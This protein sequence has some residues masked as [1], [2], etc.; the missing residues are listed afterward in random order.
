MRIF[1]INSKNPLKRIVFNRK[2][3]DI[4]LFAGN[5]VMIIVQLFD[6]TELTEHRMT[7]LNTVYLANPAHPS[8]PCRKINALG[9]AAHLS[10][11]KLNT[12]RYIYKFMYLYYFFENKQKLLHS[13][14]D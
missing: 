14:S 7:L 6:L 10:L 9:G 13:L 3:D 11:S 1:E 12:K 2:N 8:L 4:C 5:D